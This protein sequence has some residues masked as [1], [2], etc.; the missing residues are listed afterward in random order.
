ML[1]RKQAALEEIHA[2]VCAWAT[3]LQQ[4]NRAAPWTVNEV[5]PGKARA[6]VDRAAEE[7]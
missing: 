4:N 5:V 3:G 6:T 7:Q 1:I 2:G